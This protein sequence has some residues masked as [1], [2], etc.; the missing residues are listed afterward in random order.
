M[1][2]DFLYCCS[3]FTN[4]KD[5][6]SFQISI[7]YPRGGDAIALRASSARDCQ[8]WMQAIQKSSVNCRD[9][10]QKARGY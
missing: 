6:L 1:L 2:S 3:H 10:E 7:A 5:D 8:V 9:A 4:P